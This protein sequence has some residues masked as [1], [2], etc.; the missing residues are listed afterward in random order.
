MAAPVSFSSW[1]HLLLWKQYLG[2]E[3]Y[4]KSLSAVIFLNRENK[5]PEVLELLVLQWHCLRH[6]KEKLLNISLIFYLPINRHNIVYNI[7]FQLKLAKG[8]GGSSQI[9]KPNFFVV[10]FLFY[11][12]TWLSLCVPCACRSL[13]NPE[14]PRASGPDVG[15]GSWAWC[16]PYSP[17]LNLAPPRH[18]YS[19]F[20]CWQMC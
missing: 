19:L 9:R 17:F 5:T 10:V 18:L 16:R 15:A 14:C 4:S 3:Q 12:Y 7:S 8:V 11:V 1:A 20:S 2:T 13:Q 6:C